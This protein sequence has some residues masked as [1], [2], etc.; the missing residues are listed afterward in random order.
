MRLEVGAEALPGMRLTQPLGRGAFGQVWEA[1]ARDGSVVAL[2]FLD[3]RHH[4]PSVV[5][6]EVRALLALKSVEHPNLIRLHDV[7]AFSGY[8]VLNMERAD[9]NLH[10]LDEVYR[11]TTGRNIYPDHM[12]DLLEQAAAG[13]DFLAAQARN[14]FGRSALLQHCDVKPANLLLL[15]DCLK[16][17]DFGL[18]RSTFVSPSRKGFMGTP[19]YAAPEQYE[20]R[21]TERSDQ[22]AL[23]VTWCEM[24]FGHRVFNPTALEDLRRPMMP[25]DLQ[26]LR[27]REYPVI[28]RALDPRW[29]NRYPSCTA[30]VAALRE[31]INAPRTRRGATVSVGT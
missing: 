13:L 26:K 8:V 17:A 20:G 15:G 4:S 6:G 22:F 11:E 5:T 10:A 9:G 23:A 19:P 31:A 14:L 7:A 24:V 16:V 18:C 2:K 27:E 21:V 1:Q 30:F 29:T 3:C 28:A 25:V 12:L